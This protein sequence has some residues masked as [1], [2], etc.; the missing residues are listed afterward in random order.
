[1]TAKSPHT[2]KAKAPANAGSLQSKWESLAWDNVVNWAGA[3]SAARGCAYQRGG[4]VRDLGISTEGRLLATVTGQNR[5]ATG[6][7]REAGALHSRCTCPV[8]WNGCKH[9]VA[10]IATYLDMLVKGVKIP[11]AD[12]ADER[13]DKLTSDGSEKPYGDLEDN[14]GLD[15][16]GGQSDN[17]W[18][19]RKGCAAD[20]EEIRKRIDGNRP[21]FM[22]V[23]DQ[24][25]ARPVLHR[26]RPP[27]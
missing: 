21:R 15:D 4:R 23:L 25:E 7:W 17:W 19:I 26:S 8:G 27:K 9:A 10:V 3:S 6:V 20:N 12:A 11:I 5:Y 22:K 18:R 16:D 14:N 1:M 2:V 13:W 24:L